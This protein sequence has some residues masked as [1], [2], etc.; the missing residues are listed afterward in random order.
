[1]KHA[2]R[3]DSVEEVWKVTKECMVGLATWAC[4]IGRRGMG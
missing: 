1:M 3:G 4:G 2:T